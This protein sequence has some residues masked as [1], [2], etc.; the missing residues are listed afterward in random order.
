[1]FARSPVDSKQGTFMKPI[2]LTTAEV[3]C[4]ESTED[5]AQDCFKTN[6]LLFL[7]EIGHNFP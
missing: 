7:V 5:R 4:F 2:K 1:M 3:P 6:Q